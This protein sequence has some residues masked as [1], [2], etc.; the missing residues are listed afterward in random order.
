MLFGVL[1]AR[2]LAGIIANFATWRI[3][4]WLALGLQALLLVLL[5]FKLPDYPAKNKHMTYWSILFSMAKF[6][7]TEPVLVQAVIVNML[8][9][10]CF[11]NFWVS[12]LA[13]PLLFQPLTGNVRS[14]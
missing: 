8:S 1:L 11:T 4:Y 2:V 5:Y 7:V 10:A 6:T 13:V 3:V 9:M 14:P 12:G